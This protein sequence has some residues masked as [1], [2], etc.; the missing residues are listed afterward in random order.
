MLTLSFFFRQ[1]S[2]FVFMLSH[3]LLFFVVVILYLNLLPSDALRATLLSSLPL[4]K[5]SLLSEGQC[6]AT[7]QLCR[8]SFSTSVALAP[9]ASLPNSPSSPLSADVSISKISLRFFDQTEP[10]SAPWLHMAS[11]VN[12]KSS[13]TV[14]FSLW[15]LSNT[16]T[17]N[18]SLPL[19]RCFH[20]N[21]SARLSILSLSCHSLIFVL[22]HLVLKRGECP[23]GSWLRRGEAVRTK[24]RKTCQL[25][26]S[27]EKLIHSKCTPPQI[28]EKA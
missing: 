25:S 8:R 3:L 23:V 18:L 4:S 11:E 10:F 16:S 27:V 7:S 15:R 26:I 24:G 14:S 12:A 28:K 5:L 13:E 1:T 9:A 2:F 20:I 19:Y 21:R 6:S 17:F 22:A